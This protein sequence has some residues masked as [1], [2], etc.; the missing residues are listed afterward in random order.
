MLS[1]LTGV[2]EWALL[3][4][5]NLFPCKD[6]HIV[7]GDSV[8]TM[9]GDA[10]SRLVCATIMRE[11]IHELPGVSCSSLQVLTQLFVSTAGTDLINQKIRPCNEV[12]ILRPFRRGICLH[13]ASESANERD[14]ALTQLHPYC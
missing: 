4:L 11:P 6:G 12:G 3:S 13:S 8:A 14:Q 10:G 5:I 1:N 7:T 2:A 9:D